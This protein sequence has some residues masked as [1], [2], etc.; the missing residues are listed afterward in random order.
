MPE[1][2]M[3]VKRLL[4]LFVARVAAPKYRESSQQHRRIHVIKTSTLTFLAF[5][6]LT[7]NRRSAMAAGMSTV[8]V[9]SRLLAKRSLGDWKLRLPALLV[10]FRAALGP[11]DH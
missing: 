6:Y 3:A 10:S 4:P 2:A 1:T 11:H 9:H 5:R 8:L 7:S